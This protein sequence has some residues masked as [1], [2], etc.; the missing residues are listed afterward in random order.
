MGRAGASSAPDSDRIRL[1]ALERVGADWRPRKP[2]PSD[3]NRA[4]GPLALLCD[5]TL[6]EAALDDSED[7]AEEVGW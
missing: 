1:V 6:S 7:S 3:A 5:E 2:E 4:S